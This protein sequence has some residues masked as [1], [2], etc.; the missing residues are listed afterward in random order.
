[1]KPSWQLIERHEI[2]IRVERKW[3]WGTLSYTEIKSAV[4][5]KI[6]T[7]LS[8]RV[9]WIDM[10]RLICPLLSTLIIF[11]NHLLLLWTPPASKQKQYS[12]PS[13][14]D[15][16]RTARGAVALVIIP[17]MS[18]SWSMSEHNMFQI[19]RSVKD[20]AIGLS[21]KRHWYDSNTVCGTSELLTLT[22]FVVRWFELR[23]GCVL[24]PVAYPKHYKMILSDYHQGWDPSVMLIIAL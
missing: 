9:P 23:C 20:F 8:E 2:G 1:M 4:S 11:G 12:I 5:L 19:D 7:S 3:G 17:I 18:L 13:P 14:V 22:P 6:G 16:T 10:G 15:Q 21:Q 24:Y